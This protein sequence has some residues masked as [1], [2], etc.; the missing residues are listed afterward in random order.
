VTSDADVNRPLGSPL[1][2]YKRQ[3]YPGDTF[4]EAFEIEHGHSDIERLIL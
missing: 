3:I 1:A 2:L 4:A